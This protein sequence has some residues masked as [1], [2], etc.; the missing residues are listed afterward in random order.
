MTATLAPGGV[1]VVVV[2]AIGISG[3]ASDPHVELP[4]LVAVNVNV[5]P[6]PTASPPISPILLLPDRLNASV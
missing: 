5:L 2:P 1:N 4:V 3:I 6:L